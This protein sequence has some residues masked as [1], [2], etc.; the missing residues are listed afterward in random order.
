MKIRMTALELILHLAE[1]STSPNTLQHIANIA[2]ETLDAL[3]EQEELQP[4]K[5]L[6]DKSYLRGVRDGQK[7]ER[8]QHITDEQIKMMIPEGDEW[9]YGV[10]FSEAIKFARAIE[11]KL[12]EKNGGAA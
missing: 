11:T 5:D 9:K 2:R 7:G 3:K 10:G 1:G 6:T 12:R 8:H 4:F